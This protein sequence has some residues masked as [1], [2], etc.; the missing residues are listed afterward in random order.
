[1]RRAKDP[2]RGFWA[3]PAGYVEI[4]ESVEEAAV[5]ETREETG[6]TVTLQGLRGIYSAPGLGIL[7]V[8]YAGRV[9]GGTPTPGDDVEDV[10]LFP[11]LELPRQPPAHS[12]S[13]L[14][15]WFL[16]VIGELVGHEV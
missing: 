12:G 14:D 2:L 15:G 11:S 9:V 16:S 6:L 10:G 3:P 13:P 8:A 5:R 1:M 7:I 4:D